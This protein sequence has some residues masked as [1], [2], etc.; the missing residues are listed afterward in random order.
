MKIDFLKIDGD[1]ANLPTVTATASFESGV[2]TNPTTS[3]IL[4]EST[5]NATWSTPILTG[6]VAANKVVS[7]NW[8]TDITATNSTISTTLNLAKPIKLTGSTVAVDL[9]KYARAGAGSG[10]TYIIGKDSSGNELFK[11]LLSAGSTLPSGVTLAEGATLNNLRCGLSYLKPDNSCVILSAPSSD[12]MRYGGVYYLTLDSDGFVYSA[13]PDATGETS[14]LPK[15]SYNSAGTNLAA[16]EFNIFKESQNSGLWIDE[17]TVGGETEQ[18]ELEE[19]VAGKAL[20]FNAGSSEVTFNHE[21]LVNNNTGMTEGI[22]D[23]VSGH[24][25]CEFWIKL[26]TSPTSPTPI[27]LS[28]NPQRMA[29]GVA[30]DNSIYVL[31]NGNTRSSV[32]KITI[33]S[34]T[35][36]AVVG[37]ELSNGEVYINGVTHG[38]CSGA[39]NNGFR[40]AKLNPGNSLG[41]LGTEIDEL[42]VWTSARS[43]EEITDNMNKTFEAQY[44]NKLALYYTFNELIAPSR[45]TSG[46]LDELTGNEDS[47]NNSADSVNG[48][49][50]V[51]TS[52]APITLEVTPVFDIVVT[53]NGQELS[54]TVGREYD[55]KEYLVVNMV[56]GEVIT[57][58][59]ANESESYSV[60]LP[61][62]VYAKVVVVDNSGLEQTFFPKK[63]NIHVTEYHLVPGWNLIAITGDKAET[64]PLGTCWGWTGDAYE[65][66]SKF[67]ACEGCW[68]YSTSER[69][70]Q[71]LAENST[72][73]I[74]LKVGWNLVGPTV[75]SEIPENGLH[76]Y[77]WNEM[78]QSIANDNILL[79]GI[80][81]WI[82]CL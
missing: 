10:G 29:I 15:A 38:S 5:T 17:I 43:G 57:T 69:K 6:T 31:N 68:V 40:M 45:A 47:S 34:W 42:R 48:D 21:D 26:A 24:W 27:I 52:S 71:V 13:K 19:G 30:A 33:G 80:G 51:E 82:F 7:P 22:C 65:I 20:M 1:A 76:V 18:E 59:Q 60:T 28:D 44:P 58:V 81:Y 9:T 4:N 62:G 41:Q 25:T 56:T 11:L 3:T 64:S 54:W 74:E 66:K 49:N 50:A 36:V 53:Q 77:N 23:A 8:Q 37:N 70:V 79:S 75:N 16:I 46:H 61:E 2:A 32:G 14:E 35:H 12:F 67:S 73:D 39:V 78:Y 63:G 55:V 72:Q